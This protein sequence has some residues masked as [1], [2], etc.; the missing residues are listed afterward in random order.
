MFNPV[1]TYCIRCAE[2]H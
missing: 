2:H 1:T